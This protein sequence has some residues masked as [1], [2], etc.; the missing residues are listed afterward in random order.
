MI[1]ESYASPHDADCYVAYSLGDKYS[2]WLLASDLDKQ[3][4]LVTATRQLE[5]L[6]FKGMPKTTSQEL[7]FPRVGESSIPED[8]VS[9]NI[10]L[11]VT[12][13]SEG[14]NAQ[15]DYEELAV[16]GQRYGKVGET[17]DPNVALPHIVAGIPSLEAWRLL[18][19]Y[20]DDKPTITLNRVQ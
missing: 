17:R 4:A 9:A 11:A 5:R 8:I 19:P 2:D 7:F 20:L 12:L 3:K 14:R 6:P 15:L 10:E 13:I 1:T 16:V 18:T